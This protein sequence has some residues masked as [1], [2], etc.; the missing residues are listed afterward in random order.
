MIRARPIAVAAIAAAFW[1]AP[2]SGGVASQSPTPAPAQ[3][4]PT[5]RGDAEKGQALYSKNACYQCHN[6]EAQ[7][8]AAGPR[9]GPDPITFQRFVAYV[10]A[11]RGE[12][13]PYTSAVMSDQELADVYAFVQARP[14]PP[15]LGS[16]PLLLSEVVEVDNTW[17][18][19]RRVQ[20]AS[21]EL[22]PLHEHPDSVIVYLTDARQR[23]TGADGKAVEVS[24]RAGDVAW[25]NANT[26]SE[27]NLSAQ[28]IEMIVT[29]LKTGAKRPTSS[30]ETLDPVK[31][32]PEHHLVPVE[33]ARVRV[34]RT[35]L[36]PHLK[37]PMHD[38]PHYV[39]VYLTGLHTTMKLADGRLM[40]N[41]R[42]AG[43]VA[44]RDA[45]RH[46][47]EQTGDTTAVE[48]QIELK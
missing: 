45:L 34:L 30:P 20:Q 2:A 32:D 41:P 16:I 8:G 21:R 9:L 44:W 3:A 47:T 15:A 42:R 22:S 38:H 19:A 1:V 24:H 40:D 23:I 7:G 12:M 5:P 17:V 35:I 6:N 26:H 4:S 25:N 31:L 37:S 14:R 28:P 18:R 11:P 13:P 48:I 29:E 27:E 33:N 43:E 36:E 46:E 10:R 39:V